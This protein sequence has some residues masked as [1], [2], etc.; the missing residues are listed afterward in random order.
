MSL[1]LSDILWPTG[2]F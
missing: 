1:S 2:A